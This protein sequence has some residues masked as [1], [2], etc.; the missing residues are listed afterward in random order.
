MF[1]KTAKNK[2]FHKL[3]HGLSID[4]EPLRAVYSAGC[5]QAHPRTITTPAALR[6]YRRGSLF[7]PGVKPAGSQ[8]YTARTHCQW[9]NREHF[10]EFF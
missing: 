5:Q 3:L 6:F 9:T 7:V 10:D 2:K 4:N 1:L 8:A